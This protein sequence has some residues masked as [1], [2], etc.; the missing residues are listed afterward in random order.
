[1]F[2]GVQSLVVANGGI[3]DASHAL[4]LWSSDPDRITLE[5]L[6][7]SWMT[8]GDIRGAQVPK[9]GGLSGVSP[10]AES[11]GLFGNQASAFGRYR[12]AWSSD[13]CYSSRSPQQR[14][15]RARRS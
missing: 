13:S 10:N 3:L 1:M 2:R 7:S 5:F 8:E 9:T 6:C 12:C 11:V 15:H 14:P 4:G